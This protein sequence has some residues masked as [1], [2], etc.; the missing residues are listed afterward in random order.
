MF[1]SSLPFW[2]RNFVDKGFKQSSG[3]LLHKKEDNQQIANVN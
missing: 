3:F 2:L 1:E